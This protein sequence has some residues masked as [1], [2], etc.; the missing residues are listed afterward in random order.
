[1]SRSEG[2]ADDDLRGGRAGAAGLLP[3]RS[4]RTVCRTSLLTYLLYAGR[5]LPQCGMQVVAVSFG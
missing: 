3:G 4:R 2:P 1:M 5:L